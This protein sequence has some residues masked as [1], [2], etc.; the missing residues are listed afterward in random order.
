MDNVQKWSYQL[1]A[2]EM[3]DILNSKN[4]N[5]INAV[6]TAAGKTP[7]E[8]Y[9]SSWSGSEYKG[10]YWHS[11]WGGISTQA[12]AW[13]LSEDAKAGTGNMQMSNVYPVRYVFAF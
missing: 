11:T 10:T 6:L 4:F 2:K 8:K 9:Q 12:P 5:A 3:V 1:K 13:G 7:L